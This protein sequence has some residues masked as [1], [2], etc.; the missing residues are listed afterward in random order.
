MERVRVL[1]VDDHAL[2]REGVRAHLAEED[3]FEVVGEAAG[4]REAVALA[5]ELM[6]DLILMDISMPEGNGI[7]AT[8]EIK[9][10]L[11][12]V[13]IV[14]LTVSD[15]DQNLFDALKSGAQGY[16]LKNVQP[17]VLVSS[18]RGVSFGE[19][20]ISPKM[21]PK[22]LQEFARLSN[23]SNFDSA[24]EPTP[25]E[26]EVLVLVAKGATNKEIA[27]TLSIAEN[28]VKNHLRNIMEKLH[29]QNRAE[30][31]AFAVRAGLVSSPSA[32]PHQKD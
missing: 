27:A 19:T 26:K 29:L 25:R 28:T 10:T 20:P 22:I 13:K 14:M 30:A 23:E 17:E 18:L 7:A 4:G 24:A 6:P 3:D 12:Y 15:T 16:L 5:R 21:A 1:L 2:F 8:R 11:P 31:A 9:R 32:N